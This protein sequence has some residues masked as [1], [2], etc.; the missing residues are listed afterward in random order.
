MFRTPRTLLLGPSG[1]YLSRP[2]SFQSTPRPCPH[3]IM[4][5]SGSSLSLGLTWSISHHSSI[6]ISAGCG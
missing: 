4:E 3:S 5:S 1:Q 2:R 6:V